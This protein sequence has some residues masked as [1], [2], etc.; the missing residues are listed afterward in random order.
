MDRGCTGAAGVPTTLACP[1][2]LGKAPDCTTEPILPQR[3]TTCCLHSALVK[4]EGFNTLQLKAHLLY[5]CTKS[6]PQL[7]AASAGKW[8]LPSQALKA[9]CTKLESVYDILLV[10]QGQSSTARHR[11]AATSPEQPQHCVAHRRERLPPKRDR[12]GRLYLRE[13]VQRKPWAPPC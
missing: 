5:T 2:S 3:A 11:R 13:Y 1:R 10:T 8:S 9:A 4:C 7:P 12:Y 6:R